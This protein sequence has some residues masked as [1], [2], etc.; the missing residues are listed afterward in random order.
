[1]AG[2]ENKLLGVIHSRKFWTL[3]AGLVT[4]AGAFA[5]GQID[6]A[7]ALYAAIGL[8]GTYIVGTGV[9]DAGRKTP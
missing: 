2:V 7:H 8:F 6:G 4:T 3:V 5:T 9:E 1:M